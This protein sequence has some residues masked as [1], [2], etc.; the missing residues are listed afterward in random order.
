MHTYKHKNIRHHD[1]SAPDPEHSIRTA[2]RSYLLLPK[3][4]PPPHT[5][6][7]Y[8]LLFLFSPSHAQQRPPGLIPQLHPPQ[9]MFAKTPHLA[10]AAEAEIRTPAFN[11]D[12]AHQH[13]PAVPH[14][15]AVPAP[16]V[17]VA[18]H[19]AF[20]AVRRARV[21]VCKDPSIGQ[22]RLIVGPVHRIRVHGGGPRMD[23][24]AVAVD[25]VRV[26]DVACFLV[27]CEADAV[28]PTE[29]V[30]HDP[31]V[32]GGRVEAVDV[33]RELGFRAEALLVA[34][35]RVGE[36]DGT[37]RVDDDV[38]GGVE[39][40]AVVVVHERGGFVGAFGFHVDETGRLAEGALG[41]EDDAVAEIGAAIGHVV[42]FRTADF[43][44]G[45]VVR[46][47]ELDLGDDDCFVRGGDGV[48]GG[49]RDLVGGDEEGV[50]GWME[51]ACFV[52]VRSSRVG[53]E[54]G[55]GRRRAEKAQER[56]MVDEEWTG[57]RGIGRKYRWGFPSRESA[58]RRCWGISRA[59]KLPQGFT[60]AVHTLPGAI[61]G[62]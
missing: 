13:A 57:L 46:G 26:G 53:D 21:R 38:V 15:D 49:V 6:E 14:V 9:L 54:E 42:A 55:K 24:G 18:V 56:I 10:V 12:L 28:R 8:I 29:A 30:S 43:V 36:P 51:D 27:G 60:L 52:E 34:V 5:K 37:V 47:E 35:D 62:P 22:V 32:A 1:K 31:D 7:I 48:G 4:N 11:Q 17:H 50:G 45:E 41:A 58:W 3:R 16:G 25:D 39:R 2:N 33:L 23:L 19:I 61:V 44:A 59:S 40:A 20:D